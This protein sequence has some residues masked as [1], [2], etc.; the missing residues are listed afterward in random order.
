[1]PETGTCTHTRRFE[2]IEI[3]LHLRM[4]L[5]GHMG[6]TS[7]CLEPL[8]VGSVDLSLNIDVVWRLGTSMLQT[9]YC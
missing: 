7:A 4:S 2:D 6:Q 5:V 1:M 3:R 9:H 8:R